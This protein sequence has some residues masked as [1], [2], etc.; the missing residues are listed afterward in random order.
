[1]NAFSRPKLL[2][3]GVDRAAVAVGGLGV[4]AYGWPLA[5]G[6]GLGIGVFGVARP[7][8]VASVAAHR[9]TMQWMIPVLE[10]AAAAVVLVT[11]SAFAVAWLGRRRAGTPLREGY[12][13]TLKSGAFLAA[14]PLVVAL[15]E[16]IA[17][18]REWLAILF[19]AIAAAL[20]AYSAYQTWPV[21]SSV[22]RSRPFGRAAALALV[23]VSSGAFAW[24]VASI[25]ITNHLAFNTGRA[26]LGVYVSR[27]REASQGHLLACSLCDSGRHAYAHFEP[28][29][30]LLSPAYLLNPSAQTL[31]VL[32][33]IVLASGAIAVFFFA[34]RALGKAV[35]AALA[36]AYLAYP[37]LHEVALFDFHSVALAV[38][39]SLWLL[40]ALETGRLRAYFVL[41]VVLLL[42]REDLC[43]VVAGVGAY[44]LGSVDVARRRLGWATLGLALVAFVVMQLASP[45]G[46]LATYHDVVGDFTSRVH[47]TRRPLQSAGVSVTLVQRIFSEDK[48]LYAVELLSPLLLLPLFVRGR[49][50]LLYGG[51]LVLLAEQSLSGTINA[52]QAALL[53]PFLFA[54]TVEALGAL[55]SGR[56]TCGPLVAHALGRALV[57]GILVCS[58]LECYELGPILRDVPFKAGTHPLQRAPTKDQIDLDANLRKLSASWPKGVKVAASSNL[59]PHLGAASHLYTLDDRSRSDYVV[60]FMKQRTV[61]RRM[62][63]EETAGQLVRVGTYG[64]ANVY[65]ARYRG[66]LSR[67]ARQLDDE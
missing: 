55:F 54:L 59:L 61:A 27:F 67:Q 49:V 52:E 33:A 5:I 16:P 31:I 60:A 40:Y 2:L 6:S 64:D 17:P 1:M 25:G 10:A 46:V 29:V 8:F 34:E 62:E 23:V 39:L 42:V 28:A 3:H 15:H 53:I 24:R 50:L 4:G 56:T 13:S 45:D 38:P 21:D 65:R 57:L 11:L 63:A 7:D 51:V 35:A 58:V 18:F 32:Q 9:A 43:F 36:L 66:H 14:L 22:V 19:V 12:T 37:P 48:A 30:A 44:A 41:A 26:D 47:K 20:V